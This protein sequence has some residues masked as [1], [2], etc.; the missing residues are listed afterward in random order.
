MKNME[1]II[2][3]SE[4]LEEAAEL[5]QK[6]KLIAFPTETVFGLGAIAN[7]FEAIQNVFEVKGRPNDNPLIVHVS[8]KE[9]VYKFAK[10]VSPLQEQLME[11]FWPGPL[12]II[13]PVEKGIFAKN[14]NGGLG[15]VGMRMPRQIQ[16]LRLIELVGFPLVGPSANLSGKPSPTKLDHVIHDFDGKI[17]GVVSPDED[18]TDI[19]VESTVVR[20]ENNTVYILRPG[21]VTQEMIAEATEAQVL[22]LSKEKQ[23]EDSS[24]QSPGVKYKH[25]SPSQPVMIMP[26]ELRLEDWKL[27][28]DSYSQIGLLVDDEVLQYWQNHPN[29]V[30]HYSLGLS[31]DLDSA[32]RNLYAGLRDL[33]DSQCQII[34]AQPFPQSQSSHAY[35]NRLGHAGEA[36]ELLNQDENN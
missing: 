16:T 7:H 15:T 24:I 13:F 36:I 25:Y 12:T 34:F 26:T 22:E 4:N 9:D 10:T 2:Y 33:E 30:S 27:Y 18:L 19:G 11:A 5:L 6:G 29:V 14:V 28:L 1:T 3:H 31:G 8:G 21:A 35:M 32:T 23:L 17:A 20:V